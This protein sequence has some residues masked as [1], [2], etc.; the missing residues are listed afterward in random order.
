MV[1]SISSKEHLIVAFPLLLKMDFSKIDPLI[2]P[3]TVEL[4]KIKIS[5]F[6][7]ISFNNF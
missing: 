1:F 7:S 3:S 6:C 4:V 5:F 2:I